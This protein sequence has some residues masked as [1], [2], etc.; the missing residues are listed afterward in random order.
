MMVY[1][2]NDSGSIPFRPPCF[3]SRLEK[4]LRSEYATNAMN[5]LMRLSSGRSKIFLL[6]SPAINGMHYDFFLLLFLSTISPPHSDP[7]QLAGL[8]DVWSYHLHASEAE[9]DVALVV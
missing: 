8:P 6:M 5:R 1:T 7:A 2:K 4:M 3:H 9:D